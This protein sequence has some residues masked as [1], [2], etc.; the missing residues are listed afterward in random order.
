MKSARRT[1]SAA[2]FKIHCLALLDEVGKTRETL[3]V[4]K[5]GRPVAQVVA[6]ENDT[7]RR[8]L[9]GSARCVGD[10]V[11]PIDESWDASR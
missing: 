1:I 7:E 11:A 10:I 3:I 5:R 6:L 9:R 2:E 4:T 8:P